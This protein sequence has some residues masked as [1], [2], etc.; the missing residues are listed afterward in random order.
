M[1][2]VLEC[3]NGQRI[4]LQFMRQVLKMVREECMD[5]VMMKEDVIVFV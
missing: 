2:T 5:K 1:N 3:K 4:L